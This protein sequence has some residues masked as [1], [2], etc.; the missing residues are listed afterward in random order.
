[1]SIDTAGIDITTDDNINITTTDNDLVFSIGQGRIN[2]GDDSEE[3]LVRGK[4]LVDLLD[5]LLTEL[6]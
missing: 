1:M 6:Q 3:Q 4:A 2:I 5:E